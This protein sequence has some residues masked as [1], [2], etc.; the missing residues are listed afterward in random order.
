MKTPHNIQTSLD[1]EISIAD[2][3]DF[4]K[5]HKKMILIFVIIGT[6][7]G[8]LFAYFKEPSYKGSLLISPSKVFASLDANPKFNVANLGINSKEVLLKC[9]PD[10]YKDKD[11]DKDINYDIASIVK[12]SNAKN[13]SL[14]ELSMQ[15]KNKIAIYD[16]LNSMADHILKIQNKSIEP[17]LELKENGLKIAKEKL[18]EAEE[19]KTKLNSRQINELKLS[20]KGFSVDLLYSNMI[21]FNAKDIKEIKTEINTIKIDIFTGEMQLASKVTPVRIEKKLPLIQQLGALIGLFLGLCL[22]ILIALIKQ[23]KI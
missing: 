2:M 6:I 21:L 17:L 13:G 5:S 14:I 4:F 22:G 10:F 19:F 11:K 1:D 18:K 8:G 9:N 7:L 15:D 20:D 23:M 16:C 12:V 3:I